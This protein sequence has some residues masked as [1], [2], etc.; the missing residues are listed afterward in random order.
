MTASIAQAA[1]TMDAVVCDDT[2]THVFGLDDLAMIAAPI[3]FLAL[4]AVVF[5]LADRRTR[6]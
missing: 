6:R 2:G 4:V 1:C 5:V 3:L